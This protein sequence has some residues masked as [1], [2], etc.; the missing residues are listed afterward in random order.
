MNP[1]PEL[2]LIHT[3]P[4]LVELF[5]KL[6]REML[7]G[8]R[9]L[10]VLDE[11]LLEGVR[12]RGGLARGDAERLLGHVKAGERIG[13]RAILV[14]CSTISP[15]VDGVR[16][17]IS[18]PVLKIDDAMVEKAVA[19][20]ARL[21]VCV[22]NPTTVEPTRLALLKEAARQGK[23]LK[24][25]LHLVEGAWDALA[26]GDTETHDRLVAGVAARLEAQVDAVMLAQASMV[27]SMPAILA[28]GCRIPVLSS[29]ALAIE[30]VAKVLGSGSEF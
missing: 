28:A 17:R 29:P 3:V 8:N 11:P 20:D 30:A 16:N 1:K 14:T 23:T 25:H 7:P 18:L 27:R 9:E 19:M 21:G 4:L 26:A 5:Q 2:L 24:V 10:H 15:V 13:V 12:Q 22:T 6:C